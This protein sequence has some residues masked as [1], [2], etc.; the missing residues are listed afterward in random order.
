MGWNRAVQ[1]ARFCD[2]WVIC[3]ECEFGEE[4]RRHLRSHGDVPGL[5]FVFVPKRGWETALSRV[6]GLYFL[7]YNLWHRRAFSVARR[8]H[9]QFAFDLVHH[10]TMCGFREPSYLWKL[11]APFVWG[12]VGGTQNYPWRFLGEAGIRGA[13]GEAL[14]GVANAIQLRFS[15]RVRRA[16]RRAAAFAAANTTNQNDFNRTHD[17]A[18]MLM[19]E[20]GIESV[21]GTP[22]TDRDPG[23]PLRILWS[24][25]MTPRKALSLLIKALARLPKD[26]PY[27]LRILGDGPLRR[28]WQRLAH[29]TGVQCHTT[30]MGRLPRHEALRQYA[31]ADLFAFTSLRDT[32]GTVVLEALGAGLPVVCLDHQGA[33]GVIT[34]QCGIKVPVTAPNEVIAGLSEAVTLLARDTRQWERLSRGALERAEEY[35]WSRLVERMVGVYRQ[36]LQDSRCQAQTS[37]PACK[38][39][40]A[41]FAGIPTVVVSD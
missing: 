2:T 36:V 6:P 1:T 39:E 18:P 16:V 4:I 35:V 7:M 30:W 27:E 22:R 32:T 10:A 40:A 12:P 23:R 13:I 5:H 29:R 31:W 3:E 26:V 28:R 14:R 41:G 25:L 34:D 24:G 8:F 15:P 19:S 17:V 9:E 11:D 33:H 37:T 38:R 21:M 20:T